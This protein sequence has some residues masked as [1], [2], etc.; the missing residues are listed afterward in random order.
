MLTPKRFQKL[1]VIRSLQ[2]FLITGVLGFSATAHSLTTVGDLAKATED[3][4][5]D[6]YE[7]IQ[8]QDRSLKVNLLKIEQKPVKFPLPVEKYDR[9][10]QFG[11]WINFKDDTS[12]LDTRG[13][14]LQRDSSAT[15]TVVNCRVTQGEWLDP[16][17]DQKF[18]SSSQIQIDHV[19]AL[20]HAYMTG[21]FEWSQQKRCQYA[22]Y[23][24]NTFH[25]RSVNGTENLRK[26]DR[27]PREYIPPNQNFTC[28]Y[29]K[30][31]L[32]IK[33]LWSLRLTPTE[34]DRIHE[35]VLDSQCDQNDFI[36][37]QSEITQQKKVMRD[38]ENICVG[39]PLSAFY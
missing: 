29:V 16:Y 37:D 27:S 18:E 17:T 20:K 24:G 14:V 23:M 30:N 19:V 11:G 39:A 2:L 8:N 35:I 3:Y 10:K 38:S 26:G 9:Q 5:Y 36:V 32:E 7:Q 6:E 28:E 13:L 22:N 1:S 33:Y 34:V 12:C 21:A 4:I 31:W 25:L 15:V